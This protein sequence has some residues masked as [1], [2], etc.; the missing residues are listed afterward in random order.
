MHTGQRFRLRTCPEAV[1]HRSSELALSRLGSGQVSNLTPQ[2]SSRTPATTLTCSEVAQ[3]VEGFYR[4]PS[5]PLACISAT[6]R[7]ISETRRFSGR[8]TMC[9]NHV[10]SLR[11][12][13]ITLIRATRPSDTPRSTLLLPLKVCIVRETELHLIAEFRC[14]PDPQHIST[15]YV[16]RQNLTIRMS[17]RRFTR[18]TIALARKLRT[19]LQRWPS[20]S[21]ITT[22][23]GCIRRS[24]SHRPWKRA[25]AI[26]SIASRKSWGC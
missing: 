25:L 14:N 6:S 5:S 9:R 12:S 3:R 7:P 8:A 26:T 4:L 16:E 21:C 20:T 19:T 22:S 2:R 13:P 1:R 24:A 15:S 11:S 10:C 18:A 23:G 17:M